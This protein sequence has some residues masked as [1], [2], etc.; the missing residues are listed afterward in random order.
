MLVPAPAQGAAAHLHLLRHRQAVALGQADPHQAA[1]VAG[2]EHALELGRQRV[3]EIMARVTND[4]Q[5]SSQVISPGFNFVIESGL[6]LVVPHADAAFNVSR[7]ALLIAALTQSPELLLAAARDGGLWIAPATGG[8]ALL[9]PGGR[10]D[11]GPSDGLPS[12]PFLAGVVSPDGASRIVSFEP[13]PWPR[14]VF[15]LPDGT[16]IAQELLVPRGASATALSWR[17]LSGAGAARPRRDQ[18]ARR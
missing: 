11:F 7:S 8:L 17:R 10:R 9:R 18:H 3:G 5:Q 4:V 14:W 16:R 15:A 12:A 6:S 2:P 1:P 13:F